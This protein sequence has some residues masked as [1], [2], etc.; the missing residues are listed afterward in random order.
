[1]SPVS[2]QWWQFLLFS[3]FLMTLTSLMSKD[4]IFHSTSLKLGL[5]DI[6]LMIK[7]W[8]WVF[9]KNS[10][11]PKW[12]HDV[13][14]G[15]YSYDIASALTL[16]TWLKLCLPGPSRFSF[17]MIIFP[18]LYFYALEVTKSSSCNEEVDIKLL[19]QGYN[20]LYYLEF[21][22]KKDLFSPVYLVNHILTSVCIYFVFG[23]II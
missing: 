5:F 14:L 18:F 10:T 2:S 8:L 15:L 22:C 1:M 21:S 6:F 9:R 16:M 20:L 19:L 13:I 4:E 11:K 3:L 23:F 17:K 12:P 7:V